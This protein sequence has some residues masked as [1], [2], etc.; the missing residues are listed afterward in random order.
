VI[1]SGKYEIQRDKSTTSFQK[2]E[3]DVQRG[4]FYH[5]KKEKFAQVLGEHIAL[6]DLASLKKKVFALKRTISSYKYDK[7][8]I[9]NI[10][11]KRKI[12][13]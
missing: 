12:D 5:F 6:D 2:I 10:D 3:S 7:E 11:S 13:I 4:C 8:G 9:S 1:G